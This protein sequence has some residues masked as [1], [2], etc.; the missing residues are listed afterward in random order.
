MIIY[1]LAS[2]ATGVGLFYILDWFIILILP[3][4]VVSVIAGLLIRGMAPRFVNFNGAGKYTFSVLLSMIQFCIFFFVDFLMNFAVI[5]DY[6]KYIV[7]IIELGWPLLIL[8]Y[9]SFLASFFFCK[10][11]Q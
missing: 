1:F 4:Y 6:Y 11:I 7:R 5:E 2:I 10:K 8:F 9:A 3:Q